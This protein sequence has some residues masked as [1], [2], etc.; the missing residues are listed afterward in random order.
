MR[1]STG[2]HRWQPE[3]GSELRI[4][5]WK[6]RA[7]QRTPR[8]PRYAGSLTSASCSR[9]HARL[10]GSQLQQH[11]VQRR[12]RLWHR[13][14]TQRRED[15]A[16]LVHGIPAVLAD[17]NMPVPQQELRRRESAIDVGTE[18][19]GEVAGHHTPCAIGEAGPGTRLG[20]ALVDAERAALATSGARCARAARSWARPRW[21]RERT[22]PSLMPSVAEISS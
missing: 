5:G 2:R 22:V 11:G 3:R 4:P 6:T 19:V 12:G 16:L 9:G 1:R 17:D 18:L 13:P 8:S 10:L 14:F 20:R 7:F 21:M 15:A